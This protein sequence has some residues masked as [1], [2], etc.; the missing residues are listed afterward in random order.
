MVLLA[1]EQRVKML[2]KVVR[3]CVGISYGIVVADNT[4]VG[5]AAAAIVR[6]TTVV[7]R[8][9]FLMTFGLSLSARHGDV[10]NR[11]GSILSNMDKRR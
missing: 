8:T 3:G 11:T 2:N 4:T 10:A 5:V 9:I 7:D 1:G 6:S